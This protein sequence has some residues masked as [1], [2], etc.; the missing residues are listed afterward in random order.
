MQNKGALM[1]SGLLTV[2]LFSAALS[3]E[4]K[5]QA[6]GTLSCQC[7]D[8][9]AYN[10]A[11]PASHP[12]NLCAAGIH[13]NTTWLGW[14]QGKSRS[15]EFHFLDLLELIWQ[16]S[17]SNSRNSPTSPSIPNSQAD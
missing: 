17:E 2:L 8:S 7:D 15:T 16:P 13:S 10:P 12:A 6:S 11:L 14:L 5:P 1:S 9:A 3:S 4:F